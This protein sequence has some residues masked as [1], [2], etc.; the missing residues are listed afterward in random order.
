MAAQ[1]GAQEQDEQGSWLTLSEAAARSGL[2]KEALRAK[3]KRGQL[4]HRRNNRGEML[5]LLPPDLLTPAQASAQGYAQAQVEQLAELARTLETELVETK[6]E[7]DKVREVAR[8]NVEAAERLAAAQIDAKE[9]VIAE[10]KAMLA[11]A[12]KPWWRRWRA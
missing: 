6:A 7:L 3:A 11:E 2:H 12:R 9:Q 8:L 10:L 4:Q 5:V 1:D